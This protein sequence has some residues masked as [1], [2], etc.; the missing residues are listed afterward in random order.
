MT[1]EIRT[2]SGQILYFQQGDTRS[3]DFTLSFA[4][5][6]FR[7]FA[8]RLTGGCG[9]M[10]AADAIGMR[11]LEKALAGLVGRSGGK[12]SPHRRFAG[13]AIFG[14]TRMLSVHDTSVIVPGITEVFPNI[15]Q[16]CPGME[17]L[18]IVAGFRYMRRVTD[19]PNLVDKLILKTEKGFHT[20]VHPNAARALLLQPDPDNE[21]VW[22]DEWKETWRCFRSLHDCGWQTLNIVYNGG[23]VTEREIKKWAE[24]GRREPGL[25]NMLIIKDSGRKATQYASDL[26]FLSNSPSIHVCENSTEAIH[27]KLWQLGALVE[28]EERKVI[29]FRRRTG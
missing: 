10:T 6:P 7:D 13:F 29:P 4:E 21:E 11:N 9:E 5:R 15:A 18:G 25:W 22:D 17:M 12:G 23:P 14:G 26:E 27:E 19:D 1:N 2:D 8:C 28:A 3:F 16:Y 20:I 24:W